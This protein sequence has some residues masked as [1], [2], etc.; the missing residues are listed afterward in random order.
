MNADRPLT[1]Q[2][3]WEIEFSAESVIESDG[4]FRFASGSFLG[5]RFQEILETS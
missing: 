2:V 3:K 1:R 5:S 4:C